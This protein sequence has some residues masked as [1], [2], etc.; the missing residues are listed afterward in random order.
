MKW[1][2]PYVLLIIATVIWGGNFVVGRGLVADLPPI[3]ISFI[4]WSI[5]LVVLAVLYGRSLWQHL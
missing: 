5:A 3:T 1:K 4:R 2:S